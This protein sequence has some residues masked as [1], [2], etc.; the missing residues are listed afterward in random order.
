[1]IYEYSFI[2][3]WSIAAI[4]DER[5]TYESLVADERTKVYGHHLWQWTLQ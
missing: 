2:M 1:M 3:S 5:E 4:I